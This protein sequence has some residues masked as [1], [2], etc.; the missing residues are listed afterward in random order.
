MDK[1][2]TPQ[3][4]ANKKWARTIENIEPIY[5]NDLLLVVL[6]TKMLQKKTY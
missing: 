3:E 1:E 4:K 5:Q 2:L 6:L